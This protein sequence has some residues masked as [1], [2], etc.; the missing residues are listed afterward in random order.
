MSK[1][2]AELILILI[3]LLFLFVG[4]YGIT[5]PFRFQEEITA[6]YYDTIKKGHRLYPRYLSSGHI[7]RHAYSVS[8]M[9]LD[10][11]QRSTT[12]YKNK[13]LIIVNPSAYFIRGLIASVV[14]VMLVAMSMKIF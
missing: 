10:R 1:I 5:I 2:I 14:G 6:T 8:A 11:Y 7:Y 12:M 13:D 9:D 3:G 4:I